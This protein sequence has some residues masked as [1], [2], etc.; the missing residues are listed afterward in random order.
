MAAGLRAR[1]GGDV[2]VPRARRTRAAGAARRAPA[3]TDYEDMRPRDR[4][5]R[6]RYVDDIRSPNLPRTIMRVTQLAGLREAGAGLDLARS[7][8]ALTRRRGAS[9]RMA[10]R[11]RRG[12]NAVMAT[13]VAAAAVTQARSR[14]WRVAHPH[15]ARRLVQAVSDR[16][17][18]DNGQDDDADQARRGSELGRLRLVLDRGAQHD[19]AGIEEDQDRTP[20]SAAVSSTRETRPH[21]L[22]HGRPSAA[23]RKVK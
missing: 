20:R 1:S 4:R 14:W 9:S 17:G 6:R 15:H 23:H 8:S 11:C 7:A 19:Q 12:T 22:P 3:A 2:A 13:A 18:L 10:F 16:G 5:R 21:R